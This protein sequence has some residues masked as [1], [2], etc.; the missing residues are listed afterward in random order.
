MGRAGLPEKPQHIQICS[1]IQLKSADFV[2]RSTFFARA[3]SNPALTY[4]EADQV[5][6]VE[7]PDTDLETLQYYLRVA[8]EKDATVVLPANAKA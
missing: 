7:I 1:N 6:A 2:G 4:V 8:L 5:Q 3:L